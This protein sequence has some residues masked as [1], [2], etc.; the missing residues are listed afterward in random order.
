M[1]HDR[2]VSDRTVLE[3]FAESFCRVL[4]RHCG[5]IIVSGFVAIAHGR[6]RGTED[7]DVIVERIAKKEFSALFSDLKAA[8]FVCVQPGAA[9]DIYADYLLENTGIRFVKKGTFV[10]DME[11][12]LAKDALDEYQLKTR[13]KLPL[14]GLDL[15]FSS[16]EANIAF[17]EEFL[18]SEKDLEDARHLRII[19]SEGLDSKEIEKIAD[20]IKRLR[21]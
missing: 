4:E 5:Y 13:K 2:S 7:I 19:Y 16:I 9:E 12:K 20:M 17:K 14:T 11:L 1:G 8:G 6:T 3:E 15:Y 21:R 10:P 18:K